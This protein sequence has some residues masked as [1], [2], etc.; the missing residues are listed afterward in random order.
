VT[1]QAVVVFV[2]LG[3]SLRCDGCLFQGS[4]A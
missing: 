1:R 4:G 2:A 3:F